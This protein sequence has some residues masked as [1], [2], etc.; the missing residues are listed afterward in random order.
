MPYKKDFFNLTLSPSFKNKYQFLLPILGWLTPEVNNSIFSITYIITADF[1]V[2]LDKLRLNSPLGS[3]PISV[4]PFP[5]R[6]IGEVGSKISLGILRCL[7]LEVN[8]SIFSIAYLITADLRVVLDK[9]RVNSPLGS[10]PVSVAPFAPCQIGEVGF[11][12]SLTNMGYLTLEVNNS[13]FSITYLITADL[14]VVLYKLRVNSPL[15]SVLVSV[16]PFPPRQIGEVGY[17]ISLGILRC[18]TLEVNNSI[19][20]ITYLI[21]ADLRVVLDKLRVNSPLGSVPVS[22]APFPPRQIVEVGYTISLGIL[23][24]LTLEVNNSIFSI[25]Y[26]ITADLRVVLD[27]LRVNSPLGSVPVSVAPF[28]RRQMGEVGSKICLGILRCL[29]LEV[30]NCIFSITYLITADLRVDLDKLRVNSPLGSVPVSVAPFPPC[31][32]GEEGFL[33]SL[34]NLGC[35]TLEVNNSIFSITYLITADLRVVLYKLRVNS[36]LGSVLV[37][38]APFPPRQIGEAGYTISLGILRSLTLEVNNSI[39]S[40]TYLI[41]ADLRVVLDKLRVNSPLGSVPVS[42]A[43]FPPRQIGEVGYTISLGILRCL[44]LEVNNSISSIK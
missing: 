10:V 27:K 41:T 5:P 17:K 38:V 43:P 1:R 32:I 9:L 24:C 16:A 35:L 13:I 11:L 4:A 12:I 36:P 33:I 19:F 40:I 7:T 30:N 23:R 22:V 6:Q 25:T 28:P 18:L 2:V 34:T 44:T 26:L 37:S 42:V 29:T 3:V 31:Q 21:T 8:N 39:F 20:S 14:R 15:G